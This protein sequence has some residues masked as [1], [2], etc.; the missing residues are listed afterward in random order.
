MTSRILALGLIALALVACNA[1][2]LLPLDG[3]F[4]IIEYEPLPYETIQ[5]DI[6]FVVDNSNSMCEEQVALTENFERFVEGLVAIEADFN[7]AVTT[8][9]M[10]SRAGEFRTGPGSVA[11]CGVS[12]PTCPAETGPVLSWSEYETDGVVDLERLR[13]DFACVASVGTRSGE[14]GIERG[15]DAM[16]T[17]LSDGMLDYENAGFRR[18][19]AWLAVIFVTDENDCSHS[20]S[21]SFAPGEQCEWERDALTS[22]GH[23]EALLRQMEG[24][25]D[26]QRV[27][28][29]GITGPDDGERVE[30]PDVPEPA[31]TGDS[32]AAFSG[33]R[34]H[35]LIQRFGHNGVSADICHEGFGAALDR[36]STVIAAASRPRCLSGSAISADGVLVQRE[37]G[38]DWQ[39]VPSETYGVELESEQCAGATAIALD[40]HAFGATDELRVR[41]QTQ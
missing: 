14:A 40:P 10:S 28:V 35:D 38:G 33:Y 12:E 23:F 29:A 19:A 9:D 34:Y 3:N 2:D 27:I 17:A 31:C 37:T 21:A 5:T 7:I 24:T 25:D 20:E 15:L 13:A 36:I 1:P 16:A 8:T 41:Y 4:H 22:I 18:T 6:L 26:G 32:G 39:T 11:A 30:R